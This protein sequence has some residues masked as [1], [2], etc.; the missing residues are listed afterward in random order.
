[1]RTEGHQRSI[2][3]VAGSEKSGHSRIVLREAFIDEVLP[4]MRNTRGR[5]LPGTYSPHLIADLFFEQAQ[6]WERLTR[7][8]VNFG[9]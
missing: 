2:V 1:M 8:Y 6:Q 4:L 3:D 7:D 5:E 9:H